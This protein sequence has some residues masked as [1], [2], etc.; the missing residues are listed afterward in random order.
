MLFRAIRIKFHSEMAKLHSASPREITSPFIREII[1]ELHSKACNYL[2][3]IH[4][5]YFTLHRTC[6]LNNIVLTTVIEIV[7]ILDGRVRIAWYVINNLLHLI[8]VIWSHISC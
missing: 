8:I 7:E 2:Y 1:S 6:V 5:L 4:T 3:I